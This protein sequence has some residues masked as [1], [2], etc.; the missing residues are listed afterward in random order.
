MLASFAQHL[1]A[2]YDVTLVYPDHDANLWRFLT[3]QLEWVRLEARR[4]EVPTEFHTAAIT[5]PGPARERFKAWVDELWCKKDQRIGEVL[6]REEEPPEA[7][8]G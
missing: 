7:M 3:N 6:G 8:A 2:V 4:I 5:R 1:D